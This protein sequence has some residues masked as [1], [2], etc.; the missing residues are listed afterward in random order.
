MLLLS[1]CLCLIYLTIS[2]YV[3][4]ATVAK[5]GSQALGTVADT[6]NDK[7]PE[8]DSTERGFQSKRLGLK[9]QKLNVKGSKGSKDNGNVHDSQ[10]F[11]NAKITFSYL[12]FQ[13]VH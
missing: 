2:T 9:V 13:L 12:I 3:Q 11:R 4:D 10:H 5:A 1:T 6:V 8:G 7:A